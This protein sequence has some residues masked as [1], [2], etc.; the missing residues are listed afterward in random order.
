MPKLSF[1]RVQD[2]AELA[3][4]TDLL[5]SQEP[6]LEAWSKEIRRFPQF[7]HVNPLIAVVRKEVAEDTV[8]RLRAHRARMEQYVSDVKAGK[9][10]NDWVDRQLASDHC[11]VE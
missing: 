11:L 5:A 6:H 7:D 8:M 10:S 2:Q 9:F 4:V 1:R 3:R